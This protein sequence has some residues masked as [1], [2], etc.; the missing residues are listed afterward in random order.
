MHHHGYSWLGEKKAFDN[1]GVRRPAPEHA[2]PSGGDE[3]LRERHRAA[4]AD[5]PLTPVP[6]IQTAHWLV[7]PA[8]LVRGTWAEPGEAGRW[9]GTELTAY[10]ARFASPAERADEWLELLVRGAVGRLAWGGDVSLGHYLVG[11]AF[12]S[13]ALVTCSPNRADPGL[14]CPV[15]TGER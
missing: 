11:T 15:G 13:V 6:P 7:K 3:G 2:P 12:H 4:V 9:L 10:A 5:F 8:A 14:R 1:E